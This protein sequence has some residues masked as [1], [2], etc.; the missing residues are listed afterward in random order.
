MRGAEV[1]RT[2]TG[3][4]ILTALIGLVGRSKRRY[5]GYIVHVGVVLIF[6]GFAGD[7]FK[8]EEQ[9]LLKPGAEL[10]VGDFTIRHD[11]LRVTRMRRSRWS[12]A[13]SACSRVAR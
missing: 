8:Q 12:P 5:G 13:T 3:T 7:G 1:R 4:D 9:A 11:A 2:A 10:T 6:L